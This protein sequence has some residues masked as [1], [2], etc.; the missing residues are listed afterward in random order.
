MNQRKHV[1][2]I[3]LKM[4]GGGGFIHLIGGWE[5]GHLCYKT[6][7]IKISFAIDYRK[8]INKNVHTNLFFKSLFSE[9]MVNLQIEH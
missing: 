1:F 7:T 3:Y 4:G 2:N 9:F 8:K 6:V 5:G